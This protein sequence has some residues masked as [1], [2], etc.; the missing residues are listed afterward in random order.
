MARRYHSTLYRRSAKY[1]Y[2]MGTLRAPYKL[3]TMASH[4][5]STLCQFSA[6]YEHNVIIP[7]IRQYTSTSTGWQDFYNTHIQH[8]A[9]TKS[10][11]R[12][13]VL[14]QQWQACTGTALSSPTYGSILLPVLGESTAPVVAFPLGMGKSLVIVEANFKVHYNLWISVLIVMCLTIPMGKQQRAQ[15]CSSTGKYGCSAVGHYWKQ[16]CHI[17]GMMTLCSCRPANAG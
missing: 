10:Q 1:G 13:S 16:Y 3:P 5:Y 11:S 4:Y 15:Y 6:K 9:S 14:S 2:N 17:S 8:C 7:D 12:S